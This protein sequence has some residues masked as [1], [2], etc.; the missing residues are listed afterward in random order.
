MENEILEKKKALIIQIAKYEKLFE[1]N[2]IKRSVLTILFYA[3]I[4]IALFYIVDGEDISLLDVEWIFGALFAG[5]I[6]AGISF[7]V[8]SLIFSQL[9]KSGENEAK[10]LDSMRQELQ[11][12]ENN[13]F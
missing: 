1:K 8:N 5:L 9:V 11:N 2:K 3:I 4:N 6:L 12:L 7:V 13:I 10:V